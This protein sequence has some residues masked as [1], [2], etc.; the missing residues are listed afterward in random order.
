M[1]KSKR[2][3]G[4]RTRLS[5]GD[6]QQKVIPPPLASQVSQKRKMPNKTYEVR[7]SLAIY[8]C[9]LIW[10]IRNKLRHEGSCS[11]TNQIVLQVL[12]IVKE[13]KLLHHY[14]VS[15]II[16]IQSFLISTIYFKA[17]KSWFSQRSIPT[18]LFLKIKST[19]GLV[20]NRLKLSL[21]SKIIPR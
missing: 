7:K 9:K 2:L 15:T 5:R 19:S 10:Y 13:Y 6:R 18:Q 12:H 16:D 17:S 21:L 8:A 11:I 4:L 3:L 20:Q 1:I 14:L